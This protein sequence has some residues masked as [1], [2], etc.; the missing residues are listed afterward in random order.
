MKR[1]LCLFLLL[2]LLIPGGMVLASDISKATY[3]ATITVSNNGTAASGVA[4]VLSANTTAWAAAGY[5]NTSG[6]NTAIRSSA[7]ADIPYMIGYGDNPWAIWVPSIGAS[8]F[9]TDV[10]YM[11]G[12]DNMDADIRYFPGSGGMTISDDP[13]LE[14]SDNYSIQIDN[15]WLGDAG[16]VLRK[17]GAYAIARGTDNVTVEFPSVPESILQ[18]ATNAN[19][20]LSADGTDVQR[21]GER[22]YGFPTS[23]INQVDVYIR[24]VSSPTGTASLTVRKVSDDSLVG[25]VG[26]LDVST[27]TTS[28]AWKTFNSTP[29]VTA[30]ESIRISLEYS[31]GSTVN[32]VEFSQQTTDVY[33]GG[34][35]SYYAGGWTNVSTSDATF[36]VY[37]DTSGPVLAA[38]GVSVAEYD[39]EFTQNPNLLVNG[40]METGSPPSSWSATRTTFTR[41]STI[42]A[43][44]TYAGKMVANDAGG[45]GTSTINQNV[46]WDDSYKGKTFTIAAYLRAEAANDKIQL[47]RVYDGVGY[48]YS[49]A[50]AK[51]GAY[52]W[53]SE[54]FTLP[55]TATQMQ[56]GIMVKT[57]STA[58]ADD[59]LY[60]DAALLIF[61]D[62]APDFNTL[63]MYLDGVEVAQTYTEA[64]TPDAASDW[65]IGSDATP[66]IG[67]YK[68]YVGG[69]L[70]SDITWEYGTTFTDASGNGNGATPTFRTTSSDADVSAAI[71]YFAP[72]STATA[73][74]FAVSDAPLLIT[75]NIT[76]S[77]NFTSGAV[78]PGGIPGASVIDDAATAGGTPNIWIWGILT[79][80]FLA[81]SGLFISWLERTNGTGGATLLLRSVV[82]IV[83]F[84][85]LISWGIFDFWM[86]TFYLVI[87]VAVMMMSRQGEVGGSVSQHGL[88]GFLAMSWIGLTIVNRVIEGQ[89][90]TAGE[91]VWANYYAF[92]QEFKVFDIFS[93]PVLN[94]QFFTHGIPALVKWDYS[95]FGGN[96]QMFQ[97]MLYSI[98]AVVSFIIF[99][100]IIGLLYNA[101]RVR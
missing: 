16:D 37:Y 87:A 31:G 25:T 54:T 71:T 93:M 39:I 79:I 72:V 86:L 11:G 40:T 101:F 91:R 51:D 44:G 22:F 36:R 20:D 56:V 29:V 60:V 7:G 100:L 78:T 82:T 74:A 89:F 59:I 64:S 2:A 48:H 15:V 84:G 98:T 23:V 32:Y 21:M 26:T 90:L 68:H 52:H 45:A 53:V 42:V 99:G 58:D 92:T 70:M 61:G 67:R 75:A 57:V 96:A 69:N 13:D 63:R 19:S 62:S 65:V 6:N 88:I 55:A 17:D 33:A 10:L 49:D 77:G 18:E 76:T 95:F 94:F 3:R 50:A 24:K 5:F 81:T 73:P 43:Q 46:A 47:I 35:L 80:F 4:T 28:F 97:Y 41:E 30:N 66:Y 1:L 83:V 27:L 12:T 9:N 85:M 8:S 34:N 38:S 14:L